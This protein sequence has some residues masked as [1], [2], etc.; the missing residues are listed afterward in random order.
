LAIRI[1]HAKGEQTMRHSPTKTG[2]RRIGVFEF[3]EGVGGFLEISGADSTGLAVADA[4]IF[5]RL[6]DVE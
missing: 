3:E 6:P 5:R 4:I 1:R 2:D